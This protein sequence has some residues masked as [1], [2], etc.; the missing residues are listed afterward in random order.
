MYFKVIVF[1]A[2]V[3][4][5]AAQYNHGY[6]NAVSSHNIVQHQ[7]SIIA[8]A[9]QPVVGHYAAPVHQDYSAPAHYSYEYGVQD[10]HTGDFKSQQES[11][12]G[13]VVRGSYSLHE[14]DGTIR[15][16]E[17]T[18]DAHNGF[19]AVVHREGQAHQAPAYQH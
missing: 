17:Y 5:A 13:D 2:T 15:R 18:A 10:P 3:A 1:A 14:A 9:A 19:N 7:P 6:G 16:V 11:R 12:E 8:H 4:V